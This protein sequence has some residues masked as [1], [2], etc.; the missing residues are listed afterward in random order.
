MDNTTFGLR[1]EQEADIK[2][3]YPTWPYVNLGSTN[4]SGIMVPV[5]P[6]KPPLDD[7]KIKSEVDMGRLSVQ[8]LLEGDIDDFYHRATSPP[9]RRP[10]GLTGNKHQRSIDVFAG[11]DGPD[12]QWSTEDRSRFFINTGSVYRDPISKALFDSENRCVDRRFDYVLSVL[13]SLPVGMPDDL[14]WE[15]NG[16]VKWQKP[17]TANSLVYPHGP[18]M[19]INMVQNQGYECTPS[20]VAKQPRKVE[21]RPDIRPPVQSQLAH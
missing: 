15:L 21:V 8:K 16:S 4:Q 18:N 17:R 20:R 9:Y 6:V 12:S 10:D 5:L 1:P 2:N 14:A 19:H 3:F 11:P 13:E 7:G